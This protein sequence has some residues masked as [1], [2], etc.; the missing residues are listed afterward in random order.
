MWGMKNYYLN[1][2]NNAHPLRLKKIFVGAPC[3]ECD[4]F[5]VCGGRCL[6]ANLTNRWNKEAYAE[7]CS[8]VRG[9][10]KTVNKSLSRINELIMDG[11]VR[12]SDFKFMKYNGC[13]IIP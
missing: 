1:N 9:L 13:E 3:T 8:T 5:D 4:V 2:L 10:I 7:V 6:Y 12:L 11:K